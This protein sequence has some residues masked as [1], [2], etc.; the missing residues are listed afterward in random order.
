MFVV[1]CSA[2]SPPKSS[3]FESLK[4]S[5]N[6]SELNLQTF[7]SDSSK[8]VE[9]STLVVMPQHPTLQCLNSSF[10]KFINVFGMY[11]I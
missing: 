2:V 7:E 1:A 9:S 4:A 5:E 11:V 3:D 8:T 10:D 6:I